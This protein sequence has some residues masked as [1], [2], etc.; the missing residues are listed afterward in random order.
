MSTEKNPN[1]RFFTLRRRFAIL[2]VAMIVT[3][4][5]FMN[6]IFVIALIKTS[7]DSKIL[8]YCVG[9]NAFLCGLC[10]LYLIIYSLIVFFHDI[11][12]EKIEK[13]GKY[14]M[15]FKK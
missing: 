6:T 14:V 13:I 12:F 5:F 10:A 15:D 4:C 3:N 7:F 11:G 8:F 1:G 2:S 9:Y